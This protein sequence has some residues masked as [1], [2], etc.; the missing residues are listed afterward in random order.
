MGGSEKNA[1]VRFFKPCHGA[2]R[3]GKFLT[4]G[5]GPAQIVGWVF[6]SFVLNFDSEVLGETHGISLPADE[7]KTYRLFSVMGV[8]L[9]GPEIPRNC[10]N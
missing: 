7:Y 4:P 3:W 10:I 5:G 1:N 8:H 2:H 6:A 9:D